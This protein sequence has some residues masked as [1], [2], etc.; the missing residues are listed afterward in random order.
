MLNKHIY[1]ILSI[2]LIIFSSI[3][4][5]C[6]QDLWENDTLMIDGIHREVMLHSQAYDWLSY[7]CKH[8]GHRLSGSPAYQ[9]AV[10][11]TRQMLDTIGSDSVYLQHFLVPHWSRGDHTMV[12]ISNSALGSIEL[13]A[14]SLGNSVSSPLEGVHAEVIVVNSLDELENLSK[15]KV[16]G[17]I[18]FFNRPM[19]K[20]V[21]NAFHAYGKTVDQRYN[22]PNL[23]ARM[24]AVAAVVRSVTTKSDDEPHTGSTLYDPE[25]INIPALALGMKS[26]DVLQLALENGPV[27]LFIQSQSKFLD[28]KWSQNVIAEI[29]GSEF[30]NE[31]IL[32]SG[33]LDSWDQGEGAHDDG[34]GCIHAMDV[35]HTFIRMG[36]KPKRTIRCV[37]FSNE[38]N[39]LRG[40][41]HYAESVIQK[42]ERNIAA[43]ESDR[44]GFTPR[45]FS[46]EGDPPG[47]I[48]NFKKVGAWE[49]LLLPF[50]LQ[51]EVGG[52][53]ADIKPLQPQGTLLIGFV[54]D[55]Q[56]YFDYHHAAT[57]VLEIVNERELKLGS[58]AITSLIFLIDKY[59][60]AH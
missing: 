22:G 7:L 34:T 16:K 27:T 31:V 60:L 5:V 20:D 14:L 58:A 55:S 39:G 43:L 6:S 56:R 40:G 29:S 44:G 19:P 52:S 24:G 32:V 13:K 36:Y 46:F 3:S 47:F 33:H 59:G 30:P 25:G 21:I 4:S 28:E 35:L 26:A 11:Y 37:L 8:V 48:L 54:P 51:F 12:R 50:G 17:K 15:D 45:G 23:A 41:A 57:D 49:D 2:Y 42:G 18:V 1:R 38:E 53:G 10:E 9:S